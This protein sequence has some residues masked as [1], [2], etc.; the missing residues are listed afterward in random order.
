LL[1]LEAQELGWDPDVERR[2]ALADEAIVLARRTGDPRVLASVLR[3]AILAYTSPDTLARRI[4]LSRE[5]L[6][7]AKA[8]QDPALAFWAHA[9]QFNLAV[10]NAAC[11][12][13]DRALRRMETGAR[14]LGQ[15]LLS[16]NAAYSKAGWFLPR[17]KPVAAE[18]LIEDAFQLGQQAGEPNAALIYGLQLT[19]LRLYQGR[20]DEVVTVLETSVDNFPQVSGWRAA[21]ASTYGLIGRRAEGVVIVEVAAKNRFGDV[22]FDEGRTTALA[23]YADVAFEAGLPSAARILYELME[24]WSD[25]IVWNGAATFGH[26]RMWL[27]LLAARL[28]W[29]DRAERDLAFACEF[30]ERHGIPLWAARGYLGWADA[31]GDRGE[32]ARAREKAARG[33][34]LA[35]EYGY[36]ALVTRAAQTS[37]VNPA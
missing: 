10:E 35:A 21:L 4:E 25:Q 18:R 23:L 34:D 8:A 36:E 24:P 3:N 6:Q 27:G 5:M 29:H 11:A 37:R 12:S 31:L 30:H 2:R 26:A 1:A 7:S 16:W 14:E 32:D 13:A 22:L 19:Y 9:V 17:E 15:P 33:R 28:G 20:G